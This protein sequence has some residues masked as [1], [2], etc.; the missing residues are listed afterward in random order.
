MI[1]YHP[2]LIKRDG[3]EPF[4]LTKEKIHQDVISILNVYTPSSRAPIFIK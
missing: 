2:K 4:I 3:K 1:N